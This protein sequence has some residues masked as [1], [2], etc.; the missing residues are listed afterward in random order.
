M[1]AFT[2]STSEVSGLIRDDRAVKMGSIRAHHT[3]VKANT[4]G[5]VTMEIPDHLYSGVSIPKNLQNW[6]NNNLN[7]SSSAGL[8]DN[9][10]V[11]PSE[12]TV[13]KTIISANEIN[14]IRAANIKSLDG[15]VK[16]KGG[17]GVQHHQSKLAQ[18]STDLSKNLDCVSHYSKN[19][20]DQGDFSIGNYD[21]D[22][23]SNSF[24]MGKPFS[25]MNS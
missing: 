21:P 11:P 17:A 12:S 13:T 23:F 14:K 2:K 1:Q 25:D 4:F 10:F 15:S 8:K 6:H 9:K 5:F 19:Y 18:S 3:L 24:S 16:I 22:I 7:G 20:N